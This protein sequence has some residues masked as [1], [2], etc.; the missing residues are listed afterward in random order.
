M[1]KLFLIPLFFLGCNNYQITRLDTTKNVQLLNK[2]GVN[3]DSL[4]KVKD[5]YIFLTPAANGIYIYKISENYN[6]IYKKELHILIDIIK[7]SIKNNTLYI[8]GYDQKKQKPIL[9]K[10]DLI[11]Q[12]FSKEFYG[13]KYDVAKDFTFKNNQIFIT[14]THYSQDNPKIVIYSKKNK[15]TLNLPYKED[16]QYILPF[17]KGLLIIGTVYKDSYDLLIAYKTINNKTVWAKTI[18]LGMDE[19]AKKVKIKNDK[20]II[21]VISS[22]EMGASKEVTF[23]LNPKGNIIKV[24]KDSEIKPLPL[25]MRT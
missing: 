1:K 3:E 13:E 12:K 24:K 6:L 2:Y 21:T 5:G 17:K 25:K 11:S 10:Y 18:D 7:S 22:D 15:L 20:I 16:A 9:I 14:A 8:L 4:I 23:T 19:K